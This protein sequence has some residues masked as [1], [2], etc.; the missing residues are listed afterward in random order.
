LQ[1]RLY[2]NQVRVVANVIFYKDNN[3]FDTKPYNMRSWPA[4]STPD[5]RQAAAA[6]PCLYF[7]PHE[8]ITVTRFGCYRKTVS[9]RRIG[10]QIKTAI[11]RCL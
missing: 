9:M 10:V 3:K 11:R 2:G 7:K 6:Y 4:N 8:E 5:L 1:K